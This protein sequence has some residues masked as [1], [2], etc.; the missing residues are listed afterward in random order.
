MRIG[1]INSASK[2]G[3]R[4]FFF[5]IIPVMACSCTTKS[6][7]TQ[8]NLIQYGNAFTYTK[9]KWTWVQSQ[10]NIKFK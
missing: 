6:N 2:N 10:L 1:I 8:I 7:S 4:R 5:I 3:S 9:G